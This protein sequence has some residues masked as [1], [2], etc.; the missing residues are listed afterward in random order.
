MLMKIV[1]AIKEKLGDDRS[2]KVMIIGNKEVEQSFYGQLVFGNV[3]PSGVDDE[4][5]KEAQRAGIYCLSCSLCRWPFTHA[6]QG[7]LCHLYSFFFASFFRETK[8]CRASCIL[9]EVECWDWHQLIWKVSANTLVSCLL[10]QYVH[11]VKDSYF[12]KNIRII[13]LSSVVVKGARFHNILGFLTLGSWK[14]KAAC[15]H[16]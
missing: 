4:L 15:P 9:A 3:L 12:Q 13:C 16:C 5:A 10:I 2:L 11:A 1:R 7:V 6:S 14:C 8:D